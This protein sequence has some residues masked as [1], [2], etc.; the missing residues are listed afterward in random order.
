MRAYGSNLESDQISTPNPQL[1]L[2]LL[3][4]KQGFS[5]PSSATW[6]PCFSWAVL[7]WIKPTASHD[8]SHWRQGMVWNTVSLSCFFNDPL[9]Y[10]PPGFCS[11]QIHSVYYKISTYFIFFVIQ[12]M[13]FLLNSGVYWTFTVVHS[14]IVLVHLKINVNVSSLWVAKCNYHHISCIHS[15]HFRLGHSNVSGTR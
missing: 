4:N 7:L 15:R 2:K 3:G 8:W 9:I 14:I 13:F 6:K 11:S 12:S 5:L 1:A 10:C